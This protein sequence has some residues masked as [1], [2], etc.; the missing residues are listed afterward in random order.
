[1]FTNYPAVRVEG[2]TLKTFDIGPPAIERVQL[3]IKSD[4]RPVEA[5]IELWHTPAYIP[6]KMRIYTEDGKIRPIDAIIETPKHP[7]TVAV[8]NVGP[9][10]FPFIAS[11]GK[12]GLG[13]AKYSLAHLEPKLVQGGG[14]VEAY[15]FGPEVESVQVLP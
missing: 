10:E 11:V 7:K 4:G 13:A 9:Q 14:T 8:F 2:T 3:A 6:T 5:N 1:M 15:A 12:T